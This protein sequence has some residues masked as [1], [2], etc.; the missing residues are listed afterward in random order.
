MLT[1]A[2]S[3]TFE[4]VDNQDLG[5]KEKIWKLVSRYQKSS[6]LNHIQP[7]CQPMETKDKKLNQ[8][9]RPYKYSDTSKRRPYDYNLFNLFCLSYTI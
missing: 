1:N 3:N 8:W 4:K 9:L 6:I 7:R 2:L 5:L